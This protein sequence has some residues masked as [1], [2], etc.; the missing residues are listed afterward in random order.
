MTQKTVEMLVN[1]YRFSS[2]AASTALILAIFALAA[3]GFDYYAKES[4]VNPHIEYLVGILLGGTLILSLASM[5]LSTYH[6]VR[7]RGR[8]SDWFPF[9]LITWALPYVGISIYLGGA[10]IV[11]FFFAK[12]SKNRG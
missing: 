12:A 5:V 4:S 9:L 11:N 10:N 8:L 3:V 2:C 1:E 6:V 7:A